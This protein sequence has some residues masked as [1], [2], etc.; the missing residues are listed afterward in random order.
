MAL[1][2][3]AIVRFGQWWRRT[4]RSGHAYGEMAFLHPDARDPNW[5]RSVR[6]IF[7]WGGVMPAALLFSLLLALTVN[8]RWWIAAAVLFLPWPIRMAQLSK[9]QASRGL[10]PRIACVSGVS[11]MLGKLPQCLGL[12]GYHVGRISGHT[13]HLIEYKGPEPE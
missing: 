12:M 3:A 9:R 11:L 13:S 2:D 1:H 4:R 6:S 5:P 8:T 7:V 10:S